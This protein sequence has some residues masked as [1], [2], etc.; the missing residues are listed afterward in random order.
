MKFYKIMILPKL[1]KLSKALLQLSETS[2]DKGVLVADNEL[3]IGTEVFIA[4]E[5][6]ELVTAPDGEYE[7]E[8]TIIIVKDGKVA[9][10]NEK[11]ASIEEVETLE[12]ET[13]V[14][15][16]VEVLN[17]KIASLEATI[18]ELKATIAEKDAIIAELNS[19][20]AAEEFSKQT[21]AYEDVKD[22]PNSLAEAVKFINHN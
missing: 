16:E 18:E 10:I 2:T 17:E 22:S 7:T 19:A 20:K 11:E 21:P 15:N 14:N 3:A 5:E 9:E 13:P 1:F 4:N 8:S 12:E 6:G